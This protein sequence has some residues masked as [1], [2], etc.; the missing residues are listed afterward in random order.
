MHAL[1]ALA[2]HAG[3][4]AS[5]DVSANSFGRA[6]GPLLELL[7]L[8]TSLTELDASGNELGD[9]GAEALAAALLAA[10]APGDAALQAHLRTLHGAASTI[11]TAVLSDA[12]G[13]NNLRQRRCARSRLP[14][15]RTC[16]RTRTWHAHAYVHAPHARLPHAPA[17]ARSRRC[18]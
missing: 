5:L 16:T 2:A 17:G 18:G 9:W 11:A 8:Y 3:R 13:R 7:P 6:A 4:L 15:G 1:A 12:K 10:S 14:R